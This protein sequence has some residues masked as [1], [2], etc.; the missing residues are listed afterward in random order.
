MKKAIIRPIN[1]RARGAHC[2][3]PEEVVGIEL[4]AEL[5]DGPHKYFA[6]VTDSHCNGWDALHGEAEL[7]RFVEEPDT[8]G[9]CGTE[10]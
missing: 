6:R 5:Y 1:H 4:E 8:C 10:K 2:P 9:N 3:W 7:V